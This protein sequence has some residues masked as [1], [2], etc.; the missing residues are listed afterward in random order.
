MAGKIDLDHETWITGKPIIG[1]P[2]VNTHIMANLCNAMQFKVQRRMMPHDRPRPEPRSSRET[3]VKRPKN[4]AFGANRRLKVQCFGLAASIAA[5]LT[6]W[7][8]SL[9]CSASDRICAC[10]YSLCSRITSV[11]SLACSS[12]CA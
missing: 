12:A 8:I 4:P 9:A 5:R 10:T 6:T 1:Q 2:R 7:L 11:R 3:F